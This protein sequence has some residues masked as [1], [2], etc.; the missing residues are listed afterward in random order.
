MDIDALLT[1]RNS[2]LAEAKLWQRRLM[3]MQ[4]ER[5]QWKADA[6]ACH[7]SHKEWEASYDD[8]RDDYCKLEALAA[9][10]IQVRDAA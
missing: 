6:I 5:D 9:T 3:Q 8:L 4:T 1:E 10:L 2:A 7:K